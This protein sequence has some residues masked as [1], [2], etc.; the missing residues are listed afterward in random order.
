MKKAVDVHRT[1]LALFKGR[2]DYFAQQDD[3]SYHPVAYCLDTFYLRQH[4]AGDATYGIYVLNIQSY[5]HFFCIDID[6]AKN[7]LNETNFKNRT[8]KYS[9]LGQRVRDTIKTLTETLGIPREAMLLEETGGRGYHIWIFLNE[10]ISGENAVA[11]GAILKSYL[12][13]E[14]EFFPKQG[15]LTSS[16]KLGNLVKLPLGIHRKYGNNSLF[17]NLIDDEPQ[18]VDGLENNL[19]LLTRVLPTETRAI[20]ATVRDHPRIEVKTKNIDLWSNS[21]DL[22]RPFFK[23]DISILTTRCTAIRGLRSKAESGQQLSRA[24]AFHFAN[25]LISA[26]RGQD[27]VVETMRT[28][29]ASEYNEQKTLSE[30][31]KIRPLFPTSCATLVEQ[32]ICLGYC[33][34]GIRKRNSDPLLANTTPCSVWL[35]RLQGQIPTEM[36]DF[37]ARIGEPSTVRRSFFQLKAYHEHEDS[38]FFDPF[39]FEQFERDLPSNCEI[40]AAILRERSTPPFAGYVFVEIPKKLDSEYR[41]LYRKMA[42]STVHDQV[43]IQAVFNVFAPL[44]EKDFQKCSYGYRWNIDEKKT[45]CI[46]DD[47]RE[48]YPRFQNQILAALRSNPNGFY[49]CCDIK[50]Y[51]DHVDHAILA[52]QLRGIIGDSYVSKFINDVVAMYR[53]D[54]REAKGLPQGPAYARLLANLYLNDFDKF[55]VRHTTKYLRYVDDLFLFYNSKEDA[56]HGLQEVAKYLRSLGLE[57]SEEDDKKPTVTTNTDESRVR[58]SLDKIQYGILE[59]TR[60]LKHLNQRVVSDFSDAVERH[61][62]SPATLDELLKLNDYMP[63]LLYVVTE[64][65]L[66]PHPLREK[67]WAIVKYLVEQRWFFPKRLKKVFYRLLDF[68]QSDEELVALYEFMEPAHKVY[69]ILSVYGAYLSSGKHK[70][71]LECLTRT[72]VK[73]K[74]TFLR[75]FGIAIGNRLELK[76]K[77]GLVSVSYIKDLAQEDSYFTPGKWVS[78]IAYLSIGDDE[79]ATVRQLVKPNSKSLLKM[80]VLEN[81][82]GEP[83]TYLDGKYL[84]NLIDRD[85][86]ILLPAVCSVIVS[87]SSN[88]DLLEK[89]LEFVDSY[90]A[91]KPSVISMLSSKLFDLRSRA[92]RAQIEN[93]KALYELVPDQEIKRILLAV[94]LR[95]SGNGLTEIDRIDFAKSHQLK[96]RY[97]ECFLFDNLGQSIDY[98]CLEL[99]PLSRLRQYVPLDVDACKMVLEDLSEKGVLPPLKFVYNTGSEEIGLQFQFGRGLRPISM[100]DFHLD[101][102]SI[103]R[104]LRLAAQIFKK[105]CY[106]HKMLGKAPFI[107]ADNLLL[108]TSGETIV[109]RTVGRS[110]RSPYLIDGSS[111]GDEEE[112]IP[113]MVGAFLARLLVG[114]S[115]KVLEFMKE[116]HTVVESFLA[117]FLRNMSSKASGEPLSCSRFEYIVDKLSEISENNEQQ[118]AA[119]YMRERLKGTLFRRNSQRVT[120]YGISGAISEHISHLREIC[121]R[122]SLLEF[123]FRDRLALS[124]GPVRQLHWV[125][126]Q[127]LNLVLNRGIVS[128]GRNVD[129]T[130]AALVEHLLLFS[131]VSIEIMALSRCIRRG[132]NCRELP[133]EISKSSSWI[134]ISAAGYERTYDLSEF[135]IAM[136]ACP[137]DPAIEAVPEA[138]ELSL[139][140]LMLQV[141]L[142]F[143]VRIEKGYLKVRHGGTIPRTVFDHFAHACLV[144]VPRIEE[145]MRGQLAGVFDALKNNDEM[146]L[147]VIRTSLYDDLMILARDFGHVKKYLGIK[148]CFGFATGKQYFPPDV[149]CRSMLGKTITAKVPALPGVPL[150]SK[151]P[152]SRYRCSWDLQNDTM[153]NLI[154]PDD[155]LNALLLDLKT[156]KFGRVKLTFIYSGKMMLLYDVLIVIVVFILLA[157]CEHGKAVLINHAIWSSLL[158]IGSKVFVAILV[159]LIGKLIL[160]DIGHWIPRWRIWIRLLR[161]ANDRINDNPG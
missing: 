153:I 146:I 20:L 55:A 88:T 90:P 13:F 128:T 2:E 133:F 108:N 27:Y 129:P 92:G 38:L 137:K 121:N 76:N 117:L 149:M 140:Q 30:I 154:I 101:R 48:A 113:R 114:N 119:L 99:I 160:W 57:L 70:E 12:N 127:L 52:E 29:Y 62:A 138:A 7:E 89:L 111:I 83:W 54:E 25:I 158:S 74:Y 135:Q 100:N 32:G 69:F 86:A 47:W 124:L 66:I 130:Y 5:C 33:R 26:E 151:Y 106:F 115:G 14:I 4:L 107:H 49:I 95:I 22:Q 1:Y 40:I 3:S 81:L 72:A 21:R 96:D 37:L 145:E 39:D 157:I 159:G 77:L 82:G 24:E 46:F 64:E 44:I 98:D 161:T 17:F 51:Y 120:W 28:S 75:G 112:D 152:S 87:V 94:L 18:Y 93:L 103:L 59:G 139:S 132:V 19:E 9:H 67:V 148:R 155:G 50:G 42:Y 110:L 61:K 15:Q 123:E 6:I 97:N 144:R 31:E 102:T 142:S 41:L 150:T 78:E 109:F 34:E 71:L 126:K 68:S 143:D 147:P 16:R 36:G 23:G 125:S 85:D 73:D 53:H 11:F 118:M 134:H 79:R 116:P 136:M 35:T 60:Q 45:N 156:S 131:T 43:P 56:E 122:D 80:L 10:P 105:A 65:T 91:L 141:L 63:S 8:A 104:G 84:C 58:Q